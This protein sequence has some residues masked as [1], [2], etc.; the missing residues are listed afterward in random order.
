MSGGTGDAL[1]EAVKRGEGAATKEEAI[2]KALE[3]PCVEGL[4]TSSCG[5]GFV[6]ALSCFMR[7]EEHERGSKCV[8]QFVALHACMVANADEFEEF[9]KELVENEEKEGYR[10]KASASA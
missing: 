9:T 1:A 7:A 10:A 4:K 6:E 8:E 3:C 2:Q 5:D